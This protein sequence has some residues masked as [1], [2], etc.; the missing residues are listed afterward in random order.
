MLKVS[1]I[2]KK[3]IEGFVVHNINFTQQPFEKIVVAGETGS[4]K[5]TLLK[6]IAGLVQPTEGQVLF[7]E[8]RVRGPEEKLLPGHPAIGYLSQHFELRNHYRVEEELDYTNTLPQSAADQVYKICQIDHLLKRWTTD[9]SGGERQRIALA[10]VLVAAPKLIILDEPFSNLDMIHKQVLKQVIHNISHQLHISCILTSHD[11]L[12]TL[13]WADTIL[14]LKDGE[15]VQ[16]GSP[17][18]VYH[19]PVNKYVAALF[20]TYNSI[21]P[22]LAAKLPALKNEQILKPLFIRPEQIVLSNT[23]GD[24]VGVV[25]NNVF[26]GSYYEVSV[27]VEETTFIVK[28]VV[29]NVEINQPVFLQLLLKRLWYLS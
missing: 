8:K 16:Q 12:D 14:V 9:L 28:T 1:G 19:Q 25:T 7:E 22:V 29:S 27:L 5:S 6:I 21:P 18:T 20:G 11:P 10:R 26:F 13:S 23:G 15:V 3:G 24:L 17:Q 4:G 2:G